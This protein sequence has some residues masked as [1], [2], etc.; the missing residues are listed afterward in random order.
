MDVA[1]LR[2]LIQSYLSWRSEWP[3]PLRWE[4]RDMYAKHAPISV[5]KGI[6]QAIEAALPGMLGELPDALLGQL[7]N[8]PDIEMPGHVDRGGRDQ[9][10]RPIEDEWVE[11]DRYSPAAIRDLA[12]A[13]IARRGL[14]L[15]RGE[16]RHPSEVELI[17]G[18]EAAKAKMLETSNR[19]RARFQQVWNVVSVL[20]V[21]GLAGFFLWYL[22]K[23]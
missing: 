19:A 1:G 21:L 11:A 20:I 22:T 17:L 4:P 7:M 6:G 13:E 23:P 16:P 12:G 3:E 2:E 8:L 10:D 15:F 5:R 9:W 14:V 18:D